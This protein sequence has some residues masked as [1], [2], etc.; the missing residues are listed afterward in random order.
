MGETARK[1]QRK[2]EPIKKTELL[3][4]I[5]SDPSVAHEQ[6]Q[7]CKTLVAEV[8]DDEQA[9]SFSKPVSELWDPAVLTDYFENIKHPMDLGTVQT[10]LLSNTFNNSDSHFDPNLFRHQIRLVF[11]NAIDY[12]QRNT[13]LHRLASKFIHFIDS[14]LA[15]IP[16]P[17][18]SS[19]HSDQNGSASPPSDRPSTGSTADKKKRAADEEKEHSRDEHMSAQENEQDAVVEKLKTQIA[20]FEKR[21]AKSEAMLAELEIKRNIPLSFEENSKLR[22]D[23]EK[24]PWETAQKVVHILRKYVDD[25]LEQMSEEDPEFVTLEFSTVEPRLLRD[26]ESLV[27]PDPVKDRER[28]A[29]EQCE[30]DIANAKRKLRM[31]ADG[32]SG[33]KKARRRR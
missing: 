22:D 31:L 33:K 8:L 20:A 10:S 28:K 21:K 6:F 11:L 24:L 3:S 15:A 1:K 32:D 19:P 16:V 29:I 9:L 14:R 17:S 18:S 7:F 23:V 27:R 30:E 12:N 25:A 2:R 26:I 13:D 5:P 4:P